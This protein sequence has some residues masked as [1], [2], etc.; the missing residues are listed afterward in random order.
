MSDEKLRIWCLHCPFTK[1]GFPVLG[2]FGATIAPVVVLPMATWTKLCKEIPEL[3]K[4]QFEV[5]TAD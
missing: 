2:N 5:G 1:K 4:R 3:G